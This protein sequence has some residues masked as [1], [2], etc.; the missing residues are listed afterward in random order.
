M[1]RPSRTRRLAVHQTLPTQSSNTGYVYLFRRLTG[2]QENFPANS[3]RYAERKSTSGRGR[4]ILVALGL[5]EGDRVNFHQRFD[6]PKTHRFHEAVARNLGAMQRTT[7]SIRTVKL[8]NAFGQVNAEN[9]D[10]H[11][12]PPWS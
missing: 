2:W 12:R 8:E 11:R 9:V 4:Q 7:T 1:V 10:V 6:Y 3:T 5:S